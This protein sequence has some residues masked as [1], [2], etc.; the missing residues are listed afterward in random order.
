MTLLIRD[1]VVYTADDAGSLYPHGS[2]LAVDGR[3]AA[4]GDVDEIDEVVDRLDEPERQGM[5][6]LVARGGNCWPSDGSHSSAG[7]TSTW[8]AHDF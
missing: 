1:G 5:R 6:A 8:Q 4:I 2:V 7:G 3:I